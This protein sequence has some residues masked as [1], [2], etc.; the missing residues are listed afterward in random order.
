ML[1]DKHWMWMP[2]MLAAV[3]IQIFMGASLATAEVFHSKESALRT[4]FP[5]A[6]GVDKRQ[7]FLS[8]EDAETAEGLAR[9]RLASRLVTVYVG[10]K[11]D[12]IVGYAFIETH[13]VRTLPETLL[14]V[15]DPD[16]RTRGVHML[17]FHEPPEYAPSESWLEQFIGRPLDE[18]LSLRGDIA[19]ITGATMT[20]NSVTAAV[21][22]A[23]AIARVKLTE[24]TTAEASH[25][26]S[27]GSGR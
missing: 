26:P 18:E 2:L 21:R 19:G 27:T 17:A 22:R 8:V 5:D 20:A 25:D 10:H 14:I 3:L 7:L 23:L 11:A 16:G 15:V 12:Q 9:A 24:S 4:A 13:Q 1:N 6:D